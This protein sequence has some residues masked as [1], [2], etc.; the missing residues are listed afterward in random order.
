VECYKN[1]IDNSV[2]SMIIID[3]DGL[4]RMV[5]KKA[6][7]QFGLTVNEMIGKSVFDFLPKEAA[8]KNLELSRALIDSGGYRVYEIAFIIDNQAR[9]FLVVD[10]CIKDES[11]NNFAIQRNSIDI[12]ACIFI[13]EKIERLNEEFE[14]RIKELTEELLKTKNDLRQSEE[15]FRAV[16]DYTYNWEYW[17]NANGEYNY[18]SPSCN[19]ITG[20]TADEFY[21]KKDLLIEITHPDDRKLITYPHKIESKK[22]KPCEYEFRIIS[23]K[24]EERW[25]AHISQSIFGANGEYLG[26]RGSYRDI[27][28]RKHATEELKL[29]KDK[30][31]K[32]GGNKTLELER[33]RETFRTLAENTKDAIM[34]FNKQHQH[35]YVNSVVEELTKIPMEVFIGKTYSE[36]EFPPKLV[37]TFEDALDFV[38]ETKQ[39]HRI[40]FKLQNGLWI[41]WLLMPEFD[42]YGNVNSVVTSGRDITE[43]KEMQFAL[44]KSYKRE[45]EL[46]ELKDRFISMVSHEFRTPLT[47]I[48]SSSDF[49]EMGGDKLDQET[50]N[51][52]Y[53]RIRRNIDYMIKMLDEILF[54]NK[55]ESSKIHL[56]F[57]KVDLHRFCR[58]LFDETRLLYPQIKSTLKINLNENFYS[59]DVLLMRNI[60]GN[61]IANAFK[62]NKEKGSV[63]FTLS[64]EKS[65]LIYR[66]RD[67]GIGIPLKERKNVFESFT[68]MSN[69]RHIKGTGL[70]L[71]IVKKS[72]EKLGGKIFF[73]SKENEGS[74]FIIIIPIH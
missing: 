48:T 20:Y 52:Y 36:L 5:N 66:I 58:D 74:E 31:L 41:D 57:E 9:T 33:S 47:S 70:G 21:N 53:G 42:S 14:E 34:R 2:T 23:K 40:E 65:K 17:L 68:R 51:K 64:L 63:N 6:A 54:I 67:T 28:K 50:K 27:T 59:I 4:Y 16:S 49:L 8:E 12:T 26:K 46:N 62:Y 18:V 10:Q 38:F 3:Q 24:G 35:I 45:H 44:Q 72:V 43:K 56:T 61:L 30:L 22:V 55:M 69:A 60:L 11:G 73:S 15:K 37:K 13:D 7:E 39:L 29:Y 1:L 71:S 25:I 32:T 19:R